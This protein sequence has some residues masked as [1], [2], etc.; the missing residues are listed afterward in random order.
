GPI[1]SYRVKLRYSEA[2]IGPSTITTSPSSHGVR[3][4]YAA[5]NR[6]QRPPPQRRRG[7]SG[8][9]SAG[10]S[11]GAARTPTGCE[12]R[13]ISAPVRMFHL[14]GQELGEQA[15]HRQAQL[16]GAGGGDHVPQ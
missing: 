16:R 11:G 9:A 8:G 13:V 1:S 12:G 6:R 3:K 14:V 4:A 5:R 15:G 10:G 2:S 7:R